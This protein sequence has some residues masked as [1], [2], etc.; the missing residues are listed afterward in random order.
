[1]V[2]HPSDE[3][4]LEGCTSVLCSSPGVGFIANSLTISLHTGPLD[5]LDAES[6]ALSRPVK[7]VSL[8]LIDE[9]YLKCV[10]PNLLP[11]YKEPAV[12][13]PH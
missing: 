6:L 10:F 2:S 11:P 7:V 12:S 9:V 13:H 3:W 5:K 8:P 4:A 1:M